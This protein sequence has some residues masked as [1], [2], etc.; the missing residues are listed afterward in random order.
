MDTNDD[1]A[2]GLGCTC[3]RSFM[4]RISTAF[5]D[6]QMKDYSSMK[7]SGVQRIVEGFAW[8]GCKYCTIE[9][10]LAVRGPLLTLGCHDEV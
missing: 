2:C 7:M 10:G 3:T 9:Q 5:S 6:A 8:R 4:L 1:S